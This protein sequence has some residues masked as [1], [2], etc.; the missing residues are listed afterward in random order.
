M[1]VLTGVN[2]VETAVRCMKDGAFD[3]L[4]KPV[5]DTRLGRRGAP[6]GGDGPGAARERR[7]SP[8]TCSRRSCEHPEAFSAIVTASPAMRGIFQYAEAIAASGLPVL[9]TGETGVGKELI[10]RGHARAQREGGRLRPRQRRG[11]RRHALQRHAVRPQTGRLHRR[12]AGQARPDRAGGRRH[13]VPRRDRRPCRRSRRSSC[14]ACCRRG[15]T[16]PS[17]RMCRRRA[18]RGCRR[19]QPGPARDAGEG[20]VPQGPVLP[21]A[22]APRP[23]APAAQARRGPAA[24]GGPFP[25]RRQPRCSGQDAADAAEGAGRAPGARTRSRATCA[26]WKA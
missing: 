22:H 20:R 14:C 26:S 5:D 18:T 6:R 17:A 8:A 15:A 3:Y 16:T 19:H 7:S 10:A 24:A 4:L 25:R 21:A 13:A 2:E 1:I 12:R 11:A 9:V 23:P